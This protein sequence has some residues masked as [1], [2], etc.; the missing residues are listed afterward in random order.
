MAKDLIDLNNEKGGSKEGV[1]TEMSE[2][3]KCDIL[4]QLI[5]IE[6]CR[7]PIRIGKTYYNNVIQSRLCY[8]KILICLSLQH[9]I[10]CWAPFS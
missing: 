1:S 8:D 9:E 7:M 5:A 6:Q 3:P 4:T 2:G 10:Q